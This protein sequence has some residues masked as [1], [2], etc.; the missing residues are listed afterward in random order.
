M[1]KLT[2]IS[3]FIFWAVVVAILVSGLVFYQNN[4]VKPA[5]NF[6]GTVNTPSD[7]N[8][9]LANGLASGV[10]PASSPAALANNQAADFQLSMA[11]I[12]KHNTSGNCWLLI[13]NEVYDVTSFMAAHPGGAGTIIP[14]CGKE[15]TQAYN[16]KGSNKSHSSN[17][18]SMLADYFIGNLNQVFP[19]KNNVPATSLAQSGSGGNNTASSGSGQAAQGNP[20][21]SPSVP[22][23]TP[24]SVSVPGALTTLN[25]AEI[26][27]HNS[28]G[29]C[30]LLIN[31]KIY[32][33]TSFI[34]A[35]PGGAGTIIPNCGKE[36]TQAFNTKGGNTPHSGNANSMLTSY[37]IGN[38][39]QQIG[40]QQVQ[41]NIQTTN[42]VTP[43]VVGG[44]EEEDDDD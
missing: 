14:N 18:N 34:A 2:T 9:N 44:E 25:V 16:T 40:Q 22:A 12:A 5:G 27:T 35:H 24:A 42:T 10:N 8:S 17:A 39:N 20:A 37:F 26:A 4:K 33:V 38:F 41:Q 43:P 11:E 32:N 23:S 3:L 28:A 30:W 13:N 36:S 1:K 31:N 6:A 19:G 29:D 21:T 15:S 7:Q